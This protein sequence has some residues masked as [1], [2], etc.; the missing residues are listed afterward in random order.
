MRHEKSIVLSEGRTV[1]VRELR[2]KD[3]R[4]LVQE[5][6]AFAALDISTLFGER[7]DELL[8]LSGELVSMPNGE[9]AEDL[10]LSELEQVLEAMKEVNASFLA[11]MGLSL[12]LIPSGKTTPEAPSEN[13]TERPAD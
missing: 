4:R 8:S 6:K 10:S 3:V 2:L 12:D 1:T 11:K 7:F 9:T 13:L 5:M